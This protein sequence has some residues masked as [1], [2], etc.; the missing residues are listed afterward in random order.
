VRTACCDISVA[1]RIET[2]KRTEL[3]LGTVVT[4]RTENSVLDG[5][6]HEKANE[7][8][9]KHMFFGKHQI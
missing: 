9:R 6:V 4:R 8:R 3:V 1:C 5:S 7:F 2:Q